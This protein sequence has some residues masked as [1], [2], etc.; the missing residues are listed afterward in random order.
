[1]DGLER[2]V[3]AALWSLPGFGVKTIAQVRSVFPSLGEIYER[4]V[5]AWIGELELS[6]A[7]RERLRTLDCLAEAADRLD[8][9]LR[10]LGYR[11]ID[12]DDPA[13]P[14]ALRSVP[15]APPLLFV[16][17]EGADGPP[18]RRVAIVGTRN[19]ETG[20]TRE[21][22]RLVEEIAAA[23]I[24]VVSGAAEGIDRVAHLGAL[25][26][27]GETWAF[28]ACA[29]EEMD[30]AQA[31]LRRPFLDG[32][33]TF[34]SQFP[35]GTRPDKSRFVQRNAWISG[36]AEAVVVA[37]APKKSGALITAASARKQGRPV[38]AMPGDP[39]N[40]A[41]EGS[42]QL[43]REGARP[44]L[45]VR[46]VLEALGLS[47]AVTARPPPGP[48]EREPLGPTAVRVLG[49]LTRAAMGFDELL[50]RLPGLSAGDL[51]AALLELE[52]SGHALQRPGKRYEKV[53]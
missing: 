43:L 10:R 46:D 6:E 14:P 17:G 51:A 1:M 13:W 35:P 42:N 36:S 7:Q 49:V 28:L 45:S 15:D 52:L 50:S 16:L 2:R 25:D 11:M 5:D 44:C 41:A 9:T 4:P 37:R 30:A 23:G 20:S 39:W 34:F 3:V 33:G 22:R 24:G 18:R 48:V 26:A 32:N 19:P 8:A 21:V 27:G 40:R 12:A 29:I 53:D 47:G 31:V 38:L